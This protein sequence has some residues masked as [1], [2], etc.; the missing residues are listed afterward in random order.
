MRPQPE[1]R[2]RDGGGGVRSGRRPGPCRPRPGSR[3]RNRDRPL[4]SPLEDDGDDRRD[5]PDGLRGLQKKDSSRVFD[6]DGGAC[7]QWIVLIDTISNRSLCSTGG[8]EDE[9]IT[10]TLSP[11]VCG[12]C[13]MQLDTGVCGVCVHTKFS[14]RSLCVY[15]GFVPAHVVVVLFERGKRLKVNPRI[16]LN[17]FSARSPP[18]PT[19]SPLR[20]RMQCVVQTATFSPTTKIYAH[21]TLLCVLCWTMEQLFTSTAHFPLQ[22]QQCCFPLDS[23]RRS[24]PGPS[25]PC[26]CIYTH[27]YSAWNGRRGGSGGGGGKVRRYWSLRHMQRE[28]ERLEASAVGYTAA[29]IAGPSCVRVRGASPNGPPPSQS[30]PDRATATREESNIGDGGIGGCWLVREGD[31]MHLRFARVYA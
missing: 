21:Q 26:V 11:C 23:L 24:E 17:G 22:Q 19:D 29:A 16:V 6:Q 1:E 7:P 31:S 15:T 28:R 20:M 9:K 2:R 4:R 5:R 12:L 27:M 30:P 10:Q 25:W 8:G 14:S 18:H 13:T 3:L